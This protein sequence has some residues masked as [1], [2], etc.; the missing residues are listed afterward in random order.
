M[1]SAAAVAALD[2][3]LARAGED[4]II[5]R[6]SG[7]APNI[8]TYEVTCRAFVRTYR[9]RQEKLQSGLSE[10]DWM[11]IMSPTEIMATNWPGASPAVPDPQ[12]PRRGDKAVFHGR[13]RTIN[14]VDPIY[15]ANQLVRIEFSATG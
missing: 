1:T 7:A 4:I 2:Q 10:G 15:M 12:L 9:L 11:V 6:T 3:A 5:R 14:A 8:L 13:E